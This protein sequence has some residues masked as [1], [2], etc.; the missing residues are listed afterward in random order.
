MNRVAIIGGGAA[1]YFTA[2]NWAEKHPNDEVIILEKAKNV[3]QKVKV[4]G[5][6]RCNVTHYCFDPRELTKNYP[7]GS[8]ELI[9]PFNK[10]NPGDTIGWLAERGVELHVEEDNRM[11]PSTN[12]SQTIIDCF[13]KEAEKHGVKLWNLCGVKS[14]LQKEE[15]WE[16]LLSNDKTERFDKVVCCSGSNIEVWKL[17]KKLGLKMVDPVPSLFTFRIKDD[18]IK[19]LPGIAKDAEVKV[20]GAKTSAY[21]PVLITHK[22]LSG[23][24]ILRLSAWGAR[25]LHQQNYQFKIAV[26]WCS[27]KENEVLED[28][29]AQK[30][31]AGKRKVSENNLF[32]VPKRLWKELVSASTIKPDTNWGD[33]GKVQLSKLAQQLTSCEFQVNGKNTFKEE[34]VTAGGVD[35]S[36]IDFR[37]M[38]AKRF[39]G[40]Y[41]A[42]EVLDIDAITGGFNFQAAWTTS[43]LV[44]EN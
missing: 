16:L 7:R 12:D 17:L 41:F 36:E 23:P 24:A 18:R 3:L 35:L 11:F 21:G 25:I 28:L 22:G 5:G 38:E 2:I 26:N 30:E 14:I 43:W 9:G 15:Q 8:K 6:G 31:N 13:L 32:E 42:G 39:S 44:S 37:K 40:L 4:S 27:Y 33:L 1:G 20:M 19:E 34:F 10:F 29:K